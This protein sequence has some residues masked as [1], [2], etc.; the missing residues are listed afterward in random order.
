MGAMSGLVDPSAVAEMMRA[1]PP[2]LRAGTS[3]LQAPISTPLAAGVAAEALGQTLTAQVD[4]VLAADQHGRTYLSRQRS[5]YPFHVGRTLSTPDDPP[6]MPT[7][8]VQ[9]CSGGIFENDR[10]SWRI[11]AGEGTKAHLTSAAATIVHG[12]PAGCAAQEVEL[13]A[14][15]GSYLEYLP[16]PL[17]LFR[18]A[19]LASR[20]RVRAD[21]QAVVLVC[22]GLVSHD[23]F[24]AEQAFEW[25]DAQIRV[26][27]LTGALLVLDRLHLTGDTLSRSVP[28]VTGAFRCLG[29][30]L[31]LCGGPEVPTLLSALRAALSAHTDIYAG[32]SRLPFDRGAWVRVLAPDAAA[33]RGA[34]RSAWYAARRVLVGSEPRPRR[35]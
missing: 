24:G 27:D 29:G 13:E 17:I 34:L 5:G 7:L 18:G 8:Y 10:L 35:K 1:P 2:L 30:F 15:A 12:M 33:L 16:D 32:A 14:R 6:G 26:E 22:D 11:V 4:L 19:R 21:P 3:T 31:T 20:V 23:P 25:V 9:S 28:G